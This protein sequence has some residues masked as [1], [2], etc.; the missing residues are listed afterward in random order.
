MI[1]KKTIFLSVV[2]SISLIIIIAFI[3][4]IYLKKSSNYKFPDCNIILISIDTLRADHLPCYGYY[5]N[6]APNISKFAKEG[7]LFEQVVDT[8][9][10]TLPVHI[11]MFTSLYP[12][13]HKIL[14]DNKRTLEE[15]RITLTEQLKQKGY[16]AAAFTDGGFLNAKFGFSQGF[17]IYDD[18]GGNFV[19]IMPKVYN[20]LTKNKNKKFFLFIHTYDVHSGFEQLPYD[21][22]EGYNH[23]YTKDYSGDFTGCLNGICASNFLVWINENL[24]S[25][26]KKPG[27]IF[28][29]LENDLRYIRALYD[30][31]I[32]Y[33]DKEIGLLFKKFKKLGIYNKSLIIITSDHG[34]EFLEHGLMLHWQNYEETARVP[35]II[36][37]PSSIIKSKRIFKLV[38]TIDLMPTILDIVDIPLNDQAQGLSLM[39]LILKNELKRNFVIIQNTIRTE[40]WKY[41]SRGELYKIKEDKFE[42]RNVINKYPKIQKRLKRL[43]RA[44]IKRDKLLFERFQKGIKANRQIKMTKKEIDKLKALGYLN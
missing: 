40:E 32:N 14:A 33:V 6:T 24:K 8:G 39:P 34:E 20:W 4:T 29:N 17:D 25:K 15:E 9:G 38:S 42:K 30:G 2:V 13:V 35:L 36:K 43:L 7:I 22:P 26:G 10:G 18:E 27:D 23:L 21:S 28:S 5:R 44:V 37:F 3:I 41:F 19:K 16:K 12:S 11:S 1:K 31:G